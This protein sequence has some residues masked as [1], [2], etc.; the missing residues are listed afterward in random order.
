MKR[1]IKKMAILLLI[2]TMAFSTCAC[3]NRDGE[4]ES[5][6]AETTEQKCAS[7]HTWGEEEYD[8]ETDEV[9]HVCD[10]CGE[11]EIILYE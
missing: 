8:P 3:G 10:I 9:Y 5:S 4:E 11:K 2:F 6:T 7:G 1:S